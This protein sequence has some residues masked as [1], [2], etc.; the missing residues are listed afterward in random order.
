MSSEP[1]RV[2]KAHGIG[3]TPDNME[4]TI[5][6]F[7][8]SLLPAAMENGQID[9]MIS[10]DPF[11]TRVAETSDCVMIYQ[12]AEYPTTKDEYCC[13]IGLRKEFLREHPD[14]AAKY[15]RAMSRACDYIAQNPK[16]AAK[17]IID[18]DLCPIDDVELT[19]RLLASY[20]YKA[21][22]QGGKAS[23]L[24]CTR[25]LVDLGIVELTVSPEEFTEKAFAVVPGFESK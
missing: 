7:E 13:L 1:P 17:L 20:K 12:Q 24:A 16:D 22:V 6:A 8:D 18:N 4:V 2:L 25:D 23:Y 10:W 21:D 14:M 11:A 19:A 9:A 3:S 5:M 15:C